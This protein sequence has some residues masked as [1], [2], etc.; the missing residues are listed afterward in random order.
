[1]TLAILTPSYAPDFDAFA[2]LH[3]SVLQFTDPDV[4]HY[5]VVPDADLPLFATLKSSRM[6]L[7][8]ERELLPRSFVSTAWFA[9]AVARIPRV[10]R[11]AR[12]IA[13]NLRHPLPPLIVKLSMAIRA[14][15]DALVRLDSDCQL[16]RPI[17]ESL[18]V[19]PTGVRFYR[20]PAG[21][22][23]E[24]TRHVAWHDNARRMVG[25]AP[26]GLPPYAD[27]IGSLI[28]WDPDIVRRCTARLAEVSG[29]DWE[30]A[31]SREWE[32][33]EY[34]L[35]GEYI[36]EF[37]SADELSFTADRTLCHS[38]WDPRPLDLAGAKRFI[39]SIE[40]DDVA[41][42]VQSNSHTGPEVLD[43]IRSAVSE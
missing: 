13:V 6:V 32:F 34:V 26:D 10:P 35:Y 8:G 11:G 16:I 3:R 39:E 43:Y 37:G 15:C 25:V 27:P 31:V 30:T 41:L 36:A 12:F 19:S 14:E 20:K 2:A 5:V 42:H 9:R 4:L 18:F 28:P 24:M 40:P 17:D 7:L 29:R 33:S 38:Y 1:M 22:T 21:I 23:A